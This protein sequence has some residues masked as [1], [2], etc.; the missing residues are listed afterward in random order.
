MAQA[1]E[2][3][4]RSWG[5]RLV[6]GDLAYVFLYFAAGMT[7]FP[8]VKEFYA[9]QPLPKPSSVIAMQLVRALIYIAAALPAI[10]WIRNWRH[11]ALALGLAFAILGG[12]APLLPDNPTMPPHIRFAHAIEVGVSNFLY[13]VVLAYLF[14]PTLPTA[15]GPAHDAHPAPG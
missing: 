11:A 12:V 2:Q 13:G 3:P 14:T 9:S 10:R 8:F 6:A 4:S 7:V 15:M 5:L 1:V